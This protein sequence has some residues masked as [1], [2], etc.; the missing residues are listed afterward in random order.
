[1]ADQ[2]A[3]DG[4]VEYFDNPTHRRAKLVRITP[5]G[6]KLLRRMLD[7]QRRLAMALAEGFDE[8]ARGTAVAVLRQRRV[9]LV[10][11]ESAPLSR[12]RRR[13]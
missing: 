1:M 9:R 4:L 3:A 6:E 10:R 11:A 7:R 8:S 13:C 12:G 2:L 5:N